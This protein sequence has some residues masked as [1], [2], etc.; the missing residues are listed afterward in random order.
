ME[1]K[2]YVLSDGRV[3][4]VP[5]AQDEAFQAELKEKGLTAM[6]QSDVSGNQISSTEDATAEQKTTASTQET[7]QS[8]IKSLNSK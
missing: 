8:Q 7:D 2:I 5:A 4:K 3:K 6:I 1:D